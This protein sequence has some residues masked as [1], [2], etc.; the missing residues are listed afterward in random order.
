MSVMPYSAIARTAPGRSGFGWLPA[1]ATSAPVR[2]RNSAA[3]IG[4]RP[5]LPVQEQHPQLGRPAGCARDTEPGMQRRAGLGKR[6]RTPAQ[7]EV[8]IRVAPIETAPP[9]GDQLRRA[10]LARVVGR[11]VLRLPDGI[12]QLG[13]RELA[14][15]PPAQRVAGQPHERR[16][17]RRTNCRHAAD[18]T[19]MQIDVSSICLTY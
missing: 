19:S 7:V 5:L 17:L 8:V 6:V 18:D 14:H 2:W 1:L 11:Q 3:A 15:Q 4:D 13:V 10:Q 12:D 16:R 9:R